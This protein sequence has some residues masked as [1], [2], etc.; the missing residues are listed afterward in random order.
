MKGQTLEDYAKKQYEQNKKIKMLKQ[1]IE[2][3]EKSLNQIVQDFEKEKEVL[4]FQNEQVIKEQTEEIRQLREG[5]RLKIHDVK[6]LKALCQMILDQRSDIE[7][8]FLESLEQVK[9]EKR[10]KLEQQGFFNQKQNVQ[11]LPL[12]GP[13]NKYTGSNFEREQQSWQQSN[14]KNSVELSDLDWEDKERILRLMFSKM[15]TGQPATNWRQATVYGKSSYKGSGVGRTSVQRGDLN[16]SF[17][18]EEY[19]EEE[20]EQV[21]N[22][23]I[24][25]K[26]NIDEYAGSTNKESHQS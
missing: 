26:T 20:E 10:R 13:Q 1:K 22:T 23:N 17:R 16:R 21:S 6:N 19:D 14:Q 3:L 18:E 5:I 12:I 2:L 8:F 24:F 9:E 7:Q 15:N 11:F 25:R 4:K